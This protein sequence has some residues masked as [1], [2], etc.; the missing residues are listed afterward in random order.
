MCSEYKYPA[1]AE[2]EIEPHWGYLFSGTGMQKDAI[3]Y[4][5]L[6]W[7]CLS[8]GTILK[9][10]RK[11]QFGGG[12]GPSLLLYGKVAGGWLANPEQPSTFI[13]WSSC[14]AIKLWHLIDPHSKSNNV[15]VCVN[16][17]FRV[18]RQRGA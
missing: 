14:S 1:E 4:H 2:C 15:N 12:S 9:T 11:P 7:A 8:F 5:L 13:L 16:Y 10:V 18:R 6:H 3:Y 17:Y